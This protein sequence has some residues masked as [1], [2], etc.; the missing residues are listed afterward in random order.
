MQMDGS[1]VIA[2]DYADLW[3]GITP[4][5][6]G[7]GYRYSVMYDENGDVS[8]VGDGRVFTGSQSNGTVSGAGQPL[9]GSSAVPSKA[10]SGSA[11]KPEA[12]NF[13]TS[14]WMTVFSDVVT[15]VRPVYGMSETLTV[16]PEPATMLLLGLGGL[17]LFRRRRY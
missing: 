12:Y 3:N 7:D 9:G 4:I 8:R 5:V 1:T 2:N 10:Q 17:G 15:N 6:G 11:W 13:A 14:H 16:V